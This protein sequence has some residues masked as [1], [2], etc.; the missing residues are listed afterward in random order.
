MC[1]LSLSP[2]HPR[3]Q[4]LRDVCRRL[5]VADVGSISPAVD[6]LSRVVCV[7]PRLAALVNGVCTA[8]WGEGAD[9]A[10]H[11]MEE[12]SGGVTHAPTTLGPAVDARFG[13]RCRRP[14]Q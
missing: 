13:C 9:A 6:K 2:T 4:V 1:R 7:V 12:V 8:L 14:P 10:E 11:I 3:T 5:S